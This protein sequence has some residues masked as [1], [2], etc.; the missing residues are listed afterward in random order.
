MVSALAKFPG[1][2]H[3]LSSVALKAIVV[4]RGQLI[5]RLVSRA[6]AGIPLGGP[7]GG[8]AVT[9]VA[10]QVSQRRSSSSPKATQG[11]HRRSG[12][13]LRNRASG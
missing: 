12:A 10:S 1:G 3:D 6:H 13:H 5:Q 8:G 4:D 11:G 2:R 9:A 7:G